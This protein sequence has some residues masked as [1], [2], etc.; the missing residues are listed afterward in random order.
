MPEGDAGEGGTLDALAQVVL[1]ELQHLADELRQRLG[2]RRVG[3]DVL[4]RDDALV[5]SLLQEPVRPKEFYSYE[6]ITKS[7]S[8]KLSWFLIRSLRLF[9]SF[10]EKHLV[11]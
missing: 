6:V 4:K 1:L 11:I 8:A 2:R 9:E 3:H 10:I 7:F 5:N